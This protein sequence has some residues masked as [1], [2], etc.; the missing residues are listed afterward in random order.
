M[1]EFVKRLLWDSAAFE[2][3]SRAALLALSMAL[4]TSQS[5]GAI[6]WYAA[7]AAFLAGLIGAGEKNT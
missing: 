6:D 1:I 5:S 3:Y 2:R 4:A 7:G